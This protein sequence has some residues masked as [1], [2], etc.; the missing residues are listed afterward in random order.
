M[1]M[2]STQPPAFCA[3]TSFSHSIGVCETTRDICLWLQTSCSSGA[4]LRSPTRIDAVGV[5]TAQPGACPHLVEKSE[6]VREFRIDLRIGQVAAGRHVEIMQRDRIAQAGALAEHGRDVPAV[7][8]P[9]NDLDVEGLER[10]ARE[11]RRPRDSPS[12]R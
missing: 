9:Q 10:Q 5:L 4:T 11:T 2:A 6:L 7:V 12:A 3:A 8:L 1:R